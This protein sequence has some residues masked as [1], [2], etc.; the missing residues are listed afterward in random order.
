[1]KKLEINRLREYREM[2]NLSQSE[3]GKLMDL[4]CRTI[5]AYEVGNRMPNLATI[6]KFCKL[7][8]AKPEDL[9]PNLK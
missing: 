9:Y 5:S 8:K 1:M 4:N 7:Y 6:L 2:L 3:V